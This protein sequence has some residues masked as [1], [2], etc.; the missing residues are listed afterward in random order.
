MTYL[1][2]YYKQK[3]E[4][5]KKNTNLNDNDKRKRSETPSSGNQ[6]QNNP[7]MQKKDAFQY[8]RERSYSLPDRNTYR[9]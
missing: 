4:N 1:K 8:L 9:N 3:K 6:N 2:K 7:K 5:K